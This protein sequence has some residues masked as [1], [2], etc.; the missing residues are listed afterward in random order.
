MLVHRKI[1]PRLAAARVLVIGVGGL[2]TPAAVALATAGVGTLGLVDPDRVERSNLHRQLLYRTSDVGRPKVDAAADRLREAHG[3]V[4]VVPIARRFAPGD[5]ALVRGWDAVVDGTDTIAAKFAV[6]D[7]AVAARVPLAHA[8]A[9]GATVQLLTV[10]PGT[11]ACFRCVFEEEPP[12]GDVPSCR[13]AGALGPAVAVGGALQAAEVVRVLTGR[14]PGFADRLATLDLWTGR[15]RT[16]PVSVAR[17]CAV[18]ASSV[19]RSQVA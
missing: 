8:G 13:E 12:A 16:V 1:D 3:T 15:W 4:A 11:S 19:E 7:A 5:V 6:N 9:L 17:R 18:C 2:G 14:R 10:L